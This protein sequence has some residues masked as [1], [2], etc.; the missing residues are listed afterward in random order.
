M[1]KWQAWVG[2]GVKVVPKS[3]VGDSILGHIAVTQLTVETSE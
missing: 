1:G 3:K 2:L